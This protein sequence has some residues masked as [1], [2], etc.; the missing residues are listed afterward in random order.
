LA[1]S[2]STAA[3][4][5]GGTIDHRRDLLE[6]RDIGA[7]GHRH[8]AGFPDLL[9]H[10]FGGRRRSA[11]AVARAAEIIDDDLGT[12]ARQAQRMRTA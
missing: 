1:Q 9:D 11:A 5:F 4:L 7:I 10:G 3:P 8:A 12:P 6:V 2:K